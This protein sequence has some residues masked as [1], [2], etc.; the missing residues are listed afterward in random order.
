MV[1]LAVRP[2]EA[3]A[4][5]RQHPVE[6]FQRHIL[7]Q[8]VVAPLQK[9]VVHREHRYQP[10]LGH[11]SGHSHAVSL[12][13]THVKKP[14]RELH[15]KARQS[16]AVRHSRS[17]GA[18]APVLPRQLAQRLAEHMGKRLLR[19][20]PYLSC[21]GVKCAYAVE[22][23]RLPQRRLVAAALHGVYMHQHRPSGLPR[24]SQHR[25]QPLHVVAV[26]RPHVGKAHVLEH[27]A[28]RRQ[29]RLFQRR[30][31]LMAPLVQCPTRRQLL[32][33]L[34]VSLLEGVVLRL[35]PH[36]G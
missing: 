2:H 24:C 20:L 25:R 7:H 27:G 29:Q 16:R 1:C 33:R 26:H 12:S 35:R 21:G 9:A 31:Q 18:H 8:H 32:Q 11:A 13:N 17:D 30:F 22:F 14:P 28:H 36:P 4:I 34:P 5:H 15:G 3:A 19:R 23:L 10:L 6:L